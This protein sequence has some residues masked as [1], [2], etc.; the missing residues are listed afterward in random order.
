MYV[1]K[2]GGVATMSRLRATNESIMSQ[3]RVRAQQLKRTRYQTSGRQ[4]RQNK[5]HQTIVYDAESRE[6]CSA[7]P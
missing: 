2:L 4:K 5:T 7:P 3:S 1:E 6:G